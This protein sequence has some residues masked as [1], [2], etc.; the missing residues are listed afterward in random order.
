M[1]SFVY[2]RSTGGV[3]AIAP[4]L[5]GAHWQAER[6]R[7]DNVTGLVDR[8]TAT[9]FNCHR[10]FAFSPSSTRR[11]MA[12][13]R[14]IFSPCAAIQSSMASSCSSCMRT[15]W[16]SPGPVVLGRPIFGLDFVESR[17]DLAIHSDI[18]MSAGEEVGRQPAA[19]GVTVRVVMV[20]ECQPRRAIFEARGLF[21]MRTAKPKSPNARRRPTS[22]G[23]FM[24]LRLGRFI[25]PLA[26]LHNG[27][28]DNVQEL[29]HENSSVELFRCH[30]FKMAFAGRGKSCDAE[31][32]NARG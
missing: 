26:N 30:R 12:S 1:R 8:R 17:T 11:R 15:T 27:P 6:P 16:G 28:V 21:R 10:A 9:L 3:I 22:A 14:L 4:Y 2:L 5:H 13:G 19:A 20:I 32:A 29:Q 7:N 23:F 18:T 25:V 31:K 24:P